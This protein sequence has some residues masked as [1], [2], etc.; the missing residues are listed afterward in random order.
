VKAYR[1]SAGTSPLIL[2][3]DARWQWG[4]Y[5]YTTAA[6][7]P[8]KERPVSID[9]WYGYILY[10]VE[11][12]FPQ[13]LHNQRFFTFAWDVCRSR[14]NLLE[15]RSSS[16]TLCFSSP[17]SVNRYRRSASFSGQEDGSRKVL[18]REDEA[19]QS[20]PFLQLPPFIADLCAVWPC[21]SGGGLDSA[22]FLAEP[23]EF[24]LASLMSG[25][26]ALN[27][28]WHICSRSPLTFKNLASYI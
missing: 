21:H 11:I 26:I 10:K 4:D 3:R 6:L 7:T 24:V 8:G 27:W 12:I 25:H 23:F 20:T 9:I 16:R 28:I 14:K 1:G 17:S 22:S 18:N 2:N 19:E 13:S 15:R 5:S